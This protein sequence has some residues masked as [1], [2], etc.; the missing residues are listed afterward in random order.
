M[1]G[2][3][4]GGRKRCRAKPLWF[5]LTVSYIQ[6][7]HAL[8][9]DEHQSISAFRGERGY[10]KFHRR[11]RLDFFGDRDTESGIRTL[12][13]SGGNQGGH[14][15]T[16]RSKKSSKSSKKSSS[17]SSSHELGEFITTGRIEN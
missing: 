2:G 16:K 5:I 8:A 14:S 7:N 12:K 9:I 10:W 3:S 1:N 6:T 17:S 15:S 11:E 4:T 13:N